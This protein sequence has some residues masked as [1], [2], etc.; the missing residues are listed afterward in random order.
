MS[1]GGGSQTVTQE[2]TP[3]QIALS[4]MQLGEA[5]RNDQ[6]SRLA[7]DIILGTGGSN[8]G[9]PA[10]GVVNTDGGSVGQY[11]G[12]GGGGSS[13]PVRLSPSQFFGGT[14]GV[15]RNIQ[16]SQAQAAASTPQQLSAPLPDIDPNTINV[17]PTYS[18]DRVQDFTPDQL[19]GQEAT[20]NIAASQNQN[21][22]STIDDIIQFGTKDVLDMNNPILQNAIGA[23]INPLQ[24]RLQQQVLP[25]ISSQAQLQGAF[26]GSRQALLES[27]A[28]DDFTENAGDIS[29]Q[30]MMNAYNTGVDTF[31]RTS[32]LLPTL[33]NAR[34]LGADRLNTTGGVQ[35]QQ[36]QNELNATIDNF[37]EANTADNRALAELVSLVSGLSSG[38]NAVMS[39]GSTST[40][41]GGPSS[42]Q[43]AAGGA[44]SGF[45]IG[46]PY[47]AL[48][49]GALGL[50]G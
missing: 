37:Y 19:A 30:I 28:L 16:R 36:G 29:S 1:G 3:E 47:G 2:Q 17:D 4:R 38:N 39:G 45:A 27:Q 12:G 11:T 7:Q 14:N 20:R 15:L 5:Q 33:E 41:G 44:A 32:S 50:L 10:T 34:Y 6:L 23:A 22:S 25:G 35:Q 24:E 21:L 26:G 18:G 40:T 49:G 42:L 48:L 8:S 13:Q 46:G 9:Q 31:G 43:S